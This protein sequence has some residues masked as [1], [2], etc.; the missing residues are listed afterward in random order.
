VTPRDIEQ[1]QTE[2]LTSGRSRRTVNKILT[3]T[4]GVF[5]R[6]RRVWDLPSNPVA[7]VVRRPERYSNDLDFYSAEEVMQLVGAAVSEQ[8]A[9]IFLTASFTGLRRGE[10]VALRWRDVLFESEAIRVRASFSYGALTTPKSGRARTVPMVPAVAERLATLR[11]RE[12]LTGPDDLVF[13]GECGE[14]LDGSA[15]RRRYKAALLRAGPSRTEVPRSSPLL[16]ESGNQHPEHPRSS[17]SARARKPDDDAALLACQVPGRRGAQAR[18]GVRGGLMP[19]WL[20]GLVLVA[21]AVLG[22]MLRRGED[23]SATWCRQ[24]G[25]DS[26]FARSAYPRCPAC[27]RKR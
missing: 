24:C 8:D 7:D 12:R 18:A 2:L 6:A 10:L 4:F 26:G 27:G 9:A 3:I 21:L 14:Y 25:Y 22:R 19:D 15:L 16:R 13:P 5:E 17:A 20:P 11:E 1:W 23:R